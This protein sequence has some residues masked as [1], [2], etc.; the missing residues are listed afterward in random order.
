MELAEQMNAR[1]WTR[2]NPQKT[3]VEEVGTVERVSDPDRRTRGIAGRA[4]TLWNGR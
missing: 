3:K 2:R 1:H 4:C